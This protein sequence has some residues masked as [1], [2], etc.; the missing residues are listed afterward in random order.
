MPDVGKMPGCATDLVVKLSQGF[1]ASEK[2]EL[3]IPGKPRT[4]TQRSVR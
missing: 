3:D 2:S 1:E 4:G